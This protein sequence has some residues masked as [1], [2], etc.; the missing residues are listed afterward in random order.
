M[1]RM[2]AAAMLAS[3]SSL[4]ACQIAFTFRAQQSPGVV[5]ACPAEQA[6][7]LPPR[8]LTAII[9]RF[10]EWKG[11]TCIPRLEKPFLRG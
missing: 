3:A 5:N 6:A 7:V 2:K 11:G 10:E 1:Q 8:T 4:L 9:A